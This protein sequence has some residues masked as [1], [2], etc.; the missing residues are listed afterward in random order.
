VGCFLALHEIKLGPKKMTKPAVD[1]LSSGQ[2][3]QSASEMALSNCE[4]ERLNVRPTCK[5]PLM[6]LNMHI[7]VVQMSGCRSMKKLTNFAK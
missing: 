2:L 4:E 3:A 6:Y 5:V 1:F 7:T